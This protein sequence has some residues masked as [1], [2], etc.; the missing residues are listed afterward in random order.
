MNQSHNS[1]I[2]YV[3]LTFLLIPFFT[4]NILG[5]LLELNVLESFVNYWRY[6]CIICGIIIATKSLSAGLFKVNVPVLIMILFLLLLISTYNNQNDTIHAFYYL[7][8][9]LSIVSICFYY[10][11]KC[12][13]IKKIC[14][15]IFHYLN[16]LVILNIY[17]MLTITKVDGWVFGNK[18]NI[19]YYLIPYLLCACVKYAEREFKFKKILLPIILSVFSICFGKSTTSLFAILVAFTIYLI[20]NIKQKK[21][22]ASGPNVFYIFLASLIISYLII[23]LN[24]VS[25]LN[26]VIAYFEKEDSFGRFIIWE[27][28]LLSI[29]NNLILGIG[30]ENIDVM[31]EKFGYSQT[32]N[33]YLDILYLTGLTGLSLF[34]FILYK[35]SDSIKKLPSNIKLFVSVLISVYSV[36]FIMEGKR[37]DLM[38]YFSLI[39]IYILSVHRKN[40]KQWNHIK[41]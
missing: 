30:I 39:I 24:I 13:Y 40:T 1:I 8:E 41:I 10:G 27:D 15:I 16:V 19:I 22:I 18:N 4:P 36:V 38:F 7:L 20:Y 2:I 31:I 26:V 33:K 34:M 12:G 32:H 6:F 25:Y 17:T 37:I 29:K 35:V 23:V 14:Q 21:E 11:L 9:V 3:K 28:T 5:S